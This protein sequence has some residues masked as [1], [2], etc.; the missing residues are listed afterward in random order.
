MGNNIKSTPLATVPA[1][2]PII[3]RSATR[4]A[5]FLLP[6]LS[7]GMSLLDCGYGPGSITFGLADVV[8]PGKVVGIDIGASYIE[9]AKSAAEQQGVSNASFQE[10]SVYDLPMPENS[11]DAAFSHAVLDHLGEPLLALKEIYR[12]LRPGGVVGVRVISPEEA[13]QEPLDPVLQQCREFADRL[14]THNG[15][16]RTIHRQLP[17][18]LRKAGFGRVQLS[19]SYESFGNPGAIRMWAERMAGTFTQPPVYE[20]LSELGWAS[21]VELEQIAAAWRTWSDNPDAFFARSWRE[22]VAWK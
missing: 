1:P 8:E 5:A 6:Y 16:D 3:M 18:L 11:C 9:H 7:S 17:A 15:G 10:G 2:P 19:A 20:Q 12:V 14:L 21:Q 22:A 4:D 13:V